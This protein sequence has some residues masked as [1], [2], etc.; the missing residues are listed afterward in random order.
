MRTE[1]Q[2]SEREKQVVGVLLQGKSNKQIALAL[3]ISDRTVEF[4]LKNIYAKL[5]VNSRTEAV[6]KLGKST[7]GEHEES[8]VAERDKKA[9][10]G[11]KPILIRR[12][13]MKNLLAIIGAGIL[14]TILVIALVRANL[15]KESVQTLPT[16]IVAITTMTPI[17]T[18]TVTPLPTI[19][20]KT[21]ILEQIRQA[22]VE[23]EQ[24]VQA[25]KKTGKVDFGKD[26]KTG[27]DIFLFKDESYFRMMDLNEKLWE[28]VNQL[29]Q[30]YV[31]VYRDEFKPTPFPTQPTDEQNKAY[32]EL[33]SGP[34][35]SDS[36][37]SVAAWQQ[38]PN[39]EII[40]VYDLD[41]GNYRTVYIGDI[42]ARCEV[43]GQMLEEF[44]IAPILAKV[45]NEA[46]E[47]MIRK[48][49]GKSGLQLSFE[50]IQSLANAP[51]QNTALYK[52][53][54]GFKYYVDVESGRLAMIQPN[55][56]SHPDIPVGQ[57]KSL[58]ELRGIATQFALTNSPRL[59]EL[60]PILQYEEGGKSDIRFFTWTYRNKDWSGTDW[61]M[62]P[63]F[64][65]VAVLTNGQIATYI[66]TLDLFK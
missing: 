3:G 4:H 53:E 18:T 43:F 51:W 46:D 30:L 48:V 41:N 6:L 22:F 63:P 17:S 59:A 28:K 2:F 19:S 55:Y 20:P 14:T 49:T 33:I 35:A 47:E 58:D 11:R 26:S 57:I 1:I 27:E 50:T 24:N 13:P 7:G 29:N 31:Q 64:L 34:S 16:A 12:L 25:E 8:I 37:C 66:N 39:A 5:Q 9:D 62:M 56:P 23:F 15:P 40:K 21:H 60:K 10:N 52:D 54:S 42:W 44:R 38:D 32:Y 36:Y 61:V 45:N 65:Q